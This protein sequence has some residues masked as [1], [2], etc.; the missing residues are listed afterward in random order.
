MS[1]RD[2]VYFIIG[3]V[4]LHFVVAVSYLI[5]KITKAPKNKQDKTEE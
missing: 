1:D 3:L 5:Y 4:L 2:F